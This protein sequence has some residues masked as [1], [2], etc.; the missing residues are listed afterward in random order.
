VYPPYSL[1]GVPYFP[2]QKTGGKGMP[3]AAALSLGFLEN[4]AVLL[5]FKLYGLTNDH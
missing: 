3:P 2:L 1:S 4:P 5:C